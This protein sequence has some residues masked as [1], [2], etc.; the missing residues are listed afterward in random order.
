MRHEEPSMVSTVRGVAKMTK[1]LA[2]TLFVAGVAGF[3]YGGT[4]KLEKN[5]ERTLGNLV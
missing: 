2:V 4:V 3:S 5:P 1:H